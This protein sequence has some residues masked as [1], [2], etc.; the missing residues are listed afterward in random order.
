MIR[1]SG[2]F[3]LRCLRQAVLP[4]LSTWLSHIRSSP[5]PSKPGEVASL[6]AAMLEGVVATRSGVL[7]Q[8]RLR[9]LEV[10]GVSE[11]ASPNSGIAGLAIVEVVDQHPQQMWSRLI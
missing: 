3:Q 6:G 4:P 1:R 2:T 10:R 11:D 9:L 8:L 7:S 5:G